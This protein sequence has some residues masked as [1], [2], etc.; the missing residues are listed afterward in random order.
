MIVMAKMS[1][2]QKEEFDELCNYVK[3]NILQYGDDLAFPKQMALRLKGMA[4]GKHIAR[5]EDKMLYTYKMILFAFK[6]EERNI[7][8]YIAKTTFKNEQHKINGVC[9]IAEKNLNDIKLKAMQAHRNKKIN[10][11]KQSKIANDIKLMNEVKNNYKV[12]S[13]GKEKF[14]DL[15]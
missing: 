3:S 14:D 9:L 5:K 12:K 6:K 2:K 15:W 10:E 7:L 8:N 11:E 4:V 1:K 13:L